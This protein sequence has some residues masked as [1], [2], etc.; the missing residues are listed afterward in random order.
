MFSNH[1]TTNFSQNAAVKMF[2]DRSIFGKDIGKIL[3]LTF[4]GPPCI[5]ACVGSVVLFC[6]TQSLDCFSYFLYVFIL[7]YSFYFL[8]VYCTVTLVYLF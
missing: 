8:C 2:E 7:Q 6:R 3:W 1:F 4:F 5:L